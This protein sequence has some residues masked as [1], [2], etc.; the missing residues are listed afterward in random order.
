MLKWLG[1]KVL[2]WF[3]NSGLEAVTKY[4]TTRAQM[5]ADTQRNALNVGEQVVLQQLSAEVETNRIRAQ[6]AAQDSGWGPTKWMRPC[7][8]YPSC[9][10]YVGL[11]L[12]SWHLTHFGISDLPGEWASIPRTILLSFFIARPL[13]KVGVSIGQ[14]ISNS[15]AKRS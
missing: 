10:M 9:A 13:E 4:L 14:A 11:I 2:S 15:V 7:A 8:F 12:D 5:Q 1:I 6:V 3:G